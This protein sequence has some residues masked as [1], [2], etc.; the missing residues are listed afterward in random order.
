MLVRY[1]PSMKPYQCVYWNQRWDHAHCVIDAC[2]IKRCKTIS[3]YMTE[4]AVLT[5]IWCI[6]CVNQVVQWRINKYCVGITD[7]IDIVSLQQRTNCSQEDH[8][9]I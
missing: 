8:Y 5:D 9:D 6:Q 1:D 7:Y 4:R 3:H 2:Y